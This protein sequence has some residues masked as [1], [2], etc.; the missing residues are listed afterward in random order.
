MEV[1]AKYSLGL[2]FVCLAAISDYR[3][4][5]IKNRDVLIFL[6]SGLI[7]NIFTDGIAGGKDALLGALLPL[8]L[9]PLFVLRMLGA[10]DIKAFCALGSILGFEQSRHLI[11]F[12]FVAGGIIALLFLMFRKNAMERFKN[13]WRYLKACFYMRNLLPYDSFTDPNGKFRFAYGI[14][15]GYIITVINYYFGLI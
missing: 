3:S 9:F 10:G 4:Y 12:S 5:K 7:F 11:L 14:F 2:L 6:V 15:C 13:F 1:I 8:V